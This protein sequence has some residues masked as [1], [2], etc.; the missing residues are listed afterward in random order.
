MDVLVMNSHRQEITTKNTGWKV[1]GDFY[2][3]GSLSPSGHWIDNI[4]FGQERLDKA[5]I[6]TYYELGKSLQLRTQ[7]DHVP[8]F[9]PKMEPCCAS[10]GNER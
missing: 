7:Y 6:E 5:D 4:A 2:P 10:L 9:T 1:V 8:T 3:I